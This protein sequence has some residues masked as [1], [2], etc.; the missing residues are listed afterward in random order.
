MAVEIG[1]DMKDRPLKSGIYVSLVAGAFY[2]GK[3]NPSELD[4]KE[5]LIENAGE[6]L[7]LGEPIRNPTSDNHMQNLFKCY[8]SGQIRYL[9][10]GLFSVMW[11]DNYKEGVDL[12][13]AQCKPLKVGW[14]DLPERTLDIGILG[15]WHWIEKAM[16]DYDINPNEWNEQG[17]AK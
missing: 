8:N 3:T 15:K 12:F 11:R 17:N 1:Q 4:F 7:K 13:D 9:N 2:L 16:K 14:F 6:L 10:F 5:H